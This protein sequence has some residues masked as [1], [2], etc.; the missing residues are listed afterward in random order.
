[1]LINPAIIYDTA[2]SDYVV[3][4]R[5]GWYSFTSSHPYLQVSYI[6]Y[7]HEASEKV[8][9]CKGTPSLPDP[10]TN[11]RKNKFCIDIPLGNTSV[12]LKTLLDRS[13]KIYE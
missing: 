12:E 10:S 3:L 9:I 11:T 13:A 1:M 8:Y 5:E 2:L 7:A 6:L 4:Y